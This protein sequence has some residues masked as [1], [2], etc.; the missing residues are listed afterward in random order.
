ME[1]E[2]K[3]RQ[4]AERQRLEDEAARK[5]EEERE[6]RLEHARQLAEEQRLKKIK[7]RRDGAY[8][9][10]QRLNRPT[11]EKMKATLHSLGDTSVTV[12]DVDLLP[13]MPHNRTVDIREMNKNAV[14]GDGF[15]GTVVEKT[16]VVDD[17]ELEETYSVIRTK[18]KP[19]IGES[20]EVEL[21]A[22]DEETDDEDMLIQ[23]RV[24]FVT[25]LDES[26]Y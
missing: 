11:R 23:P 20:G 2:C 8:I 12:E 26:S 7:V 6:A 24:S 4:E 16:V 15:W 17:D 1:L 19:V 10:W 13:W 9:H 3:R 18:S 25:H 5:K 21:H 22:L 14:E